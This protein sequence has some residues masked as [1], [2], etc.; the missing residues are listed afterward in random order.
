MS[1][2][3]DSQVC[4]EGSQVCEEKKECCENPSDCEKLDCQKEQVPS[5]VAT[6]TTTVIDALSELNFSNA[7]SKFALL[8]LMTELGSKGV[9]SSD[10]VKFIFETSQVS[11]DDF[12]K[13]KVSLFE[14]YKIKEKDV[15]GA[16]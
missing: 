7:S 1:E 10:L 12:E 3:K 2:E 4:E 15:N 11:L 6:K 13:L 14:L 8:A 9:I 5:D 16:D